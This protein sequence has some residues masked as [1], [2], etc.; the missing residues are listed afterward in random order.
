[1]P[2]QA[3][4]PPPTHVVVMGVSA[5]GKT[6]LASL[7][8][9][10]LGWPLAEADDFHP[11]TNVAKMASGTPLTDD[12]R[13]P[14]LRTLRDWMDNIPGPGTVMTC[15][16]LK[17]SYRD[18]LREASGVVRFIHVVVDPTILAERISVRT[19]HFM[20][21]TLLPSQLSTLEPL[22]SDEDG[23]TLPN[24]STAE[25]LLTRALTSLDLEPKN[26]PQQ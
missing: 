16:A 9:T 12:D 19:G 8:A 13:W 17:H 10:R 24:D 1:M 18:L 2:H 3:P 6:T 20:P 14:W 15:S 25:D 22:A 4:Q 11:A 23:F 26:S 7:L 21:G 5:S